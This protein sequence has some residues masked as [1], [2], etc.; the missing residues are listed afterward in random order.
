M[1]KN[2][3]IGRLTTAKL[4]IIGA[5]LISIV[6]MSGCA[7]NASPITSGIGTDKMVAGVE[8]S[9]YL[10]VDNE[11][12]AQRLYIN[13]VKSR[14]RNNL[15]EINIELKSQYQ[16]SQKLQYHFNWF[17]SD[18]FAIEPGKTPW[19]PVELHGE[20]ST[21]LQGVAPNVNVKSFNV[22]VREIPEKAYEF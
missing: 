21:T 8:Y 7:N 1:L 5:S 4:S 16:R 9:K 13:D 14:F 20:Q 3:L 2:K 6:F 22:Y 12:L 11:Q 15:L 18:G 19:K 10:K 17:D